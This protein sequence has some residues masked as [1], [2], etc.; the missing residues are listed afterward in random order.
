MKYSSFT[1]ETLNTFLQ[2]HTA[3]N[4]TFE[5]LEGLCYWLR[6]CEP[7]QVVPA[8]RLI[9]YNLKENKPL[10]RALSTMLCRWLC[11]MRLYPLFISSGIL[12]REGFGR[13][14]KNRLYERINPSFKDVNDLRDV[15]YLLFSDKK[16]RPLD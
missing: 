13:E 15:F 2:Q 7:Q 10:A 1:P 9:K 11:S 4:N 3:T 6:Q 5:L 12:A 14:M 16:R 8:L